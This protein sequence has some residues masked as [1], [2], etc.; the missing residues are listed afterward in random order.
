LW[1]AK[2]IPSLQI[3]N[4]RAKGNAKERIKMNLQ[5]LHA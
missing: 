4:N 5:T 3:E 1:K 2:K